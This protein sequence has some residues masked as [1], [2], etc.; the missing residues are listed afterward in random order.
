MALIKARNRNQSLQKFLDLMRVEAIGG[1][2]SLFLTEPLAFVWERPQERCMFISS[3]PIS[4]LMVALKGLA[5]VESAIEQATEHVAAKKGG[6]AIHGSHSAIEFLSSRT[7]LHSFAVLTE[8]DPLKGA[9]GVYGLQLSIL[10]EIMAQRLNLRTGRCTITHQGA[11]S[12]TPTI[13]ALL[14]ASYKTLSTDPYWDVQ[15]TDV[16][17]GNQL[18]ALVSLQADATGYKS[19][20]IRR[21]LLPMLSIQGLAIDNLSEAQELLP[22]IK[23][24]DWRLVVESWLNV[25]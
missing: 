1:Q 7:Q 13:R 17:C 12:A 8:P 3:D 6:F 18:G 21:T 9:L 16:D 24:E 15:P 23:S 20:W 5:E 10:Q 11:V 25:Q 2:G 22:S 14:E 19:K 4:E